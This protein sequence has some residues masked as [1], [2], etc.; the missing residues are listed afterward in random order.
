MVASGSLSDVRR[1]QAAAAAAWA[2]GGASALTL[3]ATYVSPPSRMPNAIAA[4]VLI[5]V[6]LSFCD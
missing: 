1:A 6:H 2:A 4:I 3:P 5:N